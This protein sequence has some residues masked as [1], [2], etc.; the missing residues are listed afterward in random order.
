MFCKNCGAELTGAENVCPQ[1]GNP[2]EKEQPVMVNA[3]APTMIDNNSVNPVESQ[4]VV[5][6]PEFNAGV[7]SDQPVIEQQPIMPEQPIQ[8]TPQ[9]MMETPQGMNQ[10]PNLNQTPNM[11]QMPNMNQAPVQPMNTNT[12]QPQIQQAQTAEKKLS[13]KTIILIVV[14]VA[15]VVTGIVLIVVLGK[16]S[17]SSSTTTTPS[18]TSTTPDPVSTT[19]NNTVSFDGYTFKIPNGYVTEESDDAGL[20]IVNYDTAYSIL[21]DPV[22]NYNVYKNKLIAEFPDQANDLEVTISNRKYLVASAQED[23]LT[24]TAYISNLGTT[25]SFVGVVLKKDGSAATEEDFEVL[26]KILDSAKAG[27][28]STFAAG[29]EETNE[30]IEFPDLKPSDVTFNNE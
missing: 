18:S 21:I 26:T 2:V 24:L 13:S 10:A 27:E 28:D 29:S 5:V 14:L 1:C 23:G 15:V 17:S 20:M 8:Q 6:P 7:N 30:L 4:T 3:E 9:P 12:P 16:N 11:N 25:K 19:S 22:H